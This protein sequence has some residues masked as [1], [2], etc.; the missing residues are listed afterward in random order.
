MAGFTAGEGCF[1][2]KAYKVEHGLK[3][4]IQLEFKLTQHSRDL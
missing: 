4:I 3:T 2:V 1:A